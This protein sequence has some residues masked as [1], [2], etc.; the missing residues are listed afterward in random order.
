MPHVRYHRIAEVGRH[1]WRSSSP[2]PLLKQG[3]LE[4]IGLRILLPGKGVGC[5]LSTPVRLER[6]ALYFGCL[7]FANA[8][9]A[10]HSL[11]Y[12]PQ[13]THVARPRVH[14]CLFECSLILSSPCAPHMHF[15]KCSMAAYILTIHVQMHMV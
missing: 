5:G 11:A 4:H 6:N 7:H 8:V 15:R 3:Q 13:P 14:S 12:L 1:L 10:T 9:N 2:K